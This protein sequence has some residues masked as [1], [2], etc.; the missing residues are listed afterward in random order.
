MSSSLNGGPLCPLPEA[1]L[2]FSRAYGDWTGLGRE[3]AT[4]IC[5]DREEKTK[6]VSFRQSTRVPES[7]QLPRICRMQHTQPGRVAAIEVSDGNAKLSML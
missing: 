2:I 4:T 5:I 3:D 7:S 6:E 1:S